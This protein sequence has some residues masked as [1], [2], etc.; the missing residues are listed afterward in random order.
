MIGH[1]LELP[2]ALQFL[3]L[4]AFYL[5]TG[6][7]IHL[8]SFHGFAGRWFGSFKGIVGPFFTSVTVIFALLAAFITNDVWRRDASA[9]R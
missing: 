4:V 9:S 5:I 3:L 8:L 2:V 6:T 1:W 7:V